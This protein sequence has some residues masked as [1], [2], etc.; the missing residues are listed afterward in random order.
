MLIVIISYKSFCFPISYALFTQS[1]HQCEH[2]CVSIL[3]MLNSYPS[4]CFMLCLHKYIILLVYDYWDPHVS[5]CFHLFAVEHLMSCWIKAA[6]FL[7]SVRTLIAF[8]S[9][10]CGTIYLSSFVFVFQPV[11]GDAVTCCL[12]DG[13]SLYVLCLWHL[14]GV[15]K[16]NSNTNS[17]CK[18]LTNP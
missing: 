9:A 13:T 11:D 8:H 12:W 5:Q 6:Y 1:F 10:Y 15:I 7:Y 3:C 2:I 18:S 17:L 16:C 14:G 4:L